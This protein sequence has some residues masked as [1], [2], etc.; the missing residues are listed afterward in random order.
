M[1]SKPAFEMEGIVANVAED[2]CSGV[3]AV[4]TVGCHLPSDCLYANGDLKTLRRTNLL[5]EVPQLFGIRPERL[6]PECIS[7]IE[8]DRFTVIVRDIAEQIKKLGPIQLSV[9]GVIA[10]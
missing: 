7:A 1:L 9:K 8:G 5:K 6:R 2:L 3:D 10:Q 4:L